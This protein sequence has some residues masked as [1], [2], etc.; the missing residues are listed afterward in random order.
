MYRHLLVPLDGSELATPLVTQAVEFART[1]G[2]S[3]TFFTVREDFGATGEG[4]LQ[5]SLSPGLFVEAAAGE[6][7]AILAKAAAFAGARGVP[8]TLLVR[9]GAR[10]YE[11]ILQVAEERACDLI[12]MASHGRRGLQALM[13]GSQTRKVLDHA[14]VPVL[15]AQVETSGAGGAEQGVIDV[16]HD[17]HR[18]IAA[19][20]N[21]LRRIVSDIRQGAGLPDLEFVAAM[22]GYLRDF[23]EKVHHPRE[24]QHL[25][26]ALAG[27]F[28]TAELIRLLSAEHRAGSEALARIETLL[29]DC[30]RGEVGAPA[31]LAEALDRFIESQWQHL[32]LEETRLIPAAR[33]HLQ[34]ADWAHLAQAFKPGHGLNDDGESDHYKA[35]FVHLMNQAVDTTAN[36]PTKENQ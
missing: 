28:D 35:L 30:R 31:L 5:R 6:A 18:A 27:S 32:N 20:L 25:F 36:T 29:Q 24:E 11:L 9:T 2:A 19:V 17:E 26:A 8:C 21:G 13:L 4:A 7:N 23:P 34:A 3:I 16:I 1:L 12:F 14:R 22:V 15:V 10:P 33:Q